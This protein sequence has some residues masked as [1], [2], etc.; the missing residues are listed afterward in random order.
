M[1]LINFG[2][3][4]RKNS[5]KSTLSFI[6]A[7]INVRQPCSRPINLKKIIDLSRRKIN[8]LPGAPTCLG[9]ALLPAQ[10]HSIQTNCNSSKTFLVNCPFRCQLSCTT[11]C[12]C[13]RI[14]G[15]A[16]D[17]FGVYYHHLRELQSNYGSFTTAS[18]VCMH[19]HAF[20]KCT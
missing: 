17:R 16:V 11:L 4:T 19:L 9:L 12:C 7:L 2:F 8:S 15:R 10:A 14:L 6:Y 18:Y 3:H 5:S 20:F 1:V 13:T